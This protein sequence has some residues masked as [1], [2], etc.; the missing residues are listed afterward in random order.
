MTVV[1]GME[2]GRELGQLVAQLNKCIESEKELAASIGVDP[3]KL[4][5][6]ANDLVMVPLLAAKAQALHALVL[7][8]QRGS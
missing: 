4:R 3:F 2:L 1:G 5:D 8:N 7:V 6:S